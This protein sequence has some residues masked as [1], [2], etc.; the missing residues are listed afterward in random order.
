[1]VDLFLIR[2]SNIALRGTRISFQALSRAEEGGRDQEGARVQ[3]AYFV[4]LPERYFSLSL[5][6][7]WVF[8]GVA[9]LPRACLLEASRCIG[10][11]FS[12][13]CAT[14]QP[15]RGA[16]PSSKV[17]YGRGRKSIPLFISRK[18]HRANITKA[19]ARAHSPTVFASFFPFPFS[20][21]DGFPALPFF[22]LLAFLS[23]CVSVSSY[24]L[25]SFC[26]SAVFLGY[27]TGN[28]PCRDATGSR[29]S[30]EQCARDPPVWTRACRASKDNIG[31]KRT[32]KEGRP[33]FLLVSSSLLSS[34]LQLCLLCGMDMFSS[35]P[36]LTCLKPCPFASPLGLVLSSRCSFHRTGSLLV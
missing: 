27:N 2:Y 32:K 13:S 35:L 3:S 34:F 1:M 31:G 36:L 7:L 14:E 29:T 23:P 19:H 12:R 30:S 5:S 20:P 21:T 28:R 25:F 18:K 10:I 4:L 8:W 26:F 15:H 33:I 16:P 17:R 6:F 24:L 9:L 22:F 11:V